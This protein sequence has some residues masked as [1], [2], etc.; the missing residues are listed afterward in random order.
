MRA[1]VEKQVADAYY[2]LGKCYEAGNGVE[3]NIWEATRLYGQG[4]A[5]GSTGAMAR[6]GVMYRDGL[7][8]GRDL[9]K[10]RMWLQQ[11]ERLGHKDAPV[12]L[13]TLG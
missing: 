12:L 13:R 3:Q 4:A 1:A 6:L 9:E 2:E 5:K 7:G 8:V 11:A 10:A